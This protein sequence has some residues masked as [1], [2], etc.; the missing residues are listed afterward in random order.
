MTLELNLTFI[1]RQIPKK[2]FDNNYLERFRHF[3]I[4]GTRSGSKGTFYTEVLL[5]YLQILNI[6]FQNF[7]EAIENE[8][9][10]KVIKPD[11]IEGTDYIKE[12]RFIN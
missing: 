12:K 3:G 9:G 5:H 2:H 1:V 8:L 7:K 6:F 4:K 10:L 11:M